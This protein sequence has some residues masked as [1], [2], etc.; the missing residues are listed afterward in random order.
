MPGLVL[1][2]GQVF[3]FAFVADDEAI[4]PSVLTEPFVQRTV[5]HDFHNVD[6]KTGMVF[7]GAGVGYTTGRKT[8]GFLLGVALAYV[9]V[10]ASVPQ[11]SSCVSY[12][13][14]LI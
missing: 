6:G 2:T 5:F 13:T 4:L 7:A 3:L 9:V 8:I 1:D 10:I 11:I 12:F 14:F